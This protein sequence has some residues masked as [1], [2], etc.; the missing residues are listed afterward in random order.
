MADK[1]RPVRPTKGPI[2]TQGIDD[3][4]PNLTADGWA[5]V[6]EEAEAKRKDGA[7]KPIEDFTRGSGVCKRQ[8]TIEPLGPPKRHGD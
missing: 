5:W 7:G 4:M 6:L 2:S 8:R 3:L 1:S